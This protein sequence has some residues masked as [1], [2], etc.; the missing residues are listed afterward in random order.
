M[1]IKKDF[2]FL[3]NHIYL[4]SGAGSIKPKQVIDA[5]VDFYNNF[6]INI[7]SPNSAAGVVVMKK[8]IDTREKVAKL[9]DAKAEEVIF[10]SGTTD[11]MNRIANMLKDVLKEGDEIALTRY[12][13]SSNTIVWLELAKATGAKI[14][15]AEDIQDIIN[16]KTKIVALAQ[17]N[18]TIDKHVN[19]DDI[20]SKAK[21]VGAIVV[22]DAAQAI[23]H[24]KVSLNNSDVIVF[25][26]NKLY[27][28][29]GS[30]ALVIKSSLLNE[31]K[32]RYYGGGAV[33]KVNEDLT[34]VPKNSFWGYEAGTVNTAAIVGLGAAIDY[35]NELKANGL[36]EYE[37]E[38]ANYAHDQ[39]SKI[40]DIIVYSQRGDKA[41][42]FNIGK[43]NAQ[44][45]VSYLG[46]KNII[47]R[48]G[49]H[50]AKMLHDNGGD[51]SSIRVSLGAYNTKEDID[52]LVEAINN[53]GDFLDFI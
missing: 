36:F 10:T 9:L 12:N 38:I 19:M 11:G 4:D 52:K 27:G 48:S 23:L 13:H 2:K 50:C 18:N 30:G 51:F 16:N 26:G 53:G 3:E 31:L 43:F 49:N 1:N 40:K 6:P 44:D 5:I 41:I 20:Y 39:I 47:L 32:P 7:H 17:V 24:E 15:V 35:F 28:P 33:A 25:S 37:T 34:W 8:V 42:L 45:I 29:T 14:K 21:S 46:H 22:N